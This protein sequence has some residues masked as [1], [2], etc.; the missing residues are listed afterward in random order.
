MTSDT[1]GVVSGEQTDRLTDVERL[2]EIAELGLDRDVPRPELDAIAREAAETLGL[3]IGVVSIVLDEAQWFVATHGVD[4]WVQDAQGTPVEWSFCRNV[5][6]TSAEFVVE[7]ALEHPIMKDSPL[8]QHEGLRCYAGIPLVSSRGYVVGSFCVKG[9]E[10]R[11]F[12]EVD[13][14][15]LRGFSARAMSVIE[16]GR[17]AASPPDGR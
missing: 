6:N 11:S 2:M 17:V 8:V 4:G 15:L 16:S 5:I 3:P 7:N 10:E 12:D 1:T 9:T 14:T 13:L